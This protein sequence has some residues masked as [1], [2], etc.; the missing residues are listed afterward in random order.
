[1]LVIHGL[2]LVPSLIV[3][4]MEKM[5]V[6]VIGSG[7]AGLGAAWLMARHGVSVTVFESA[8]SAGGHAHTVLPCSETPELAVD[9]G[10]IVFNHATYPN[11]TNLFDELA[12]DVL[13]TNMSFGVSMSDGLEY[14][15]PKF[16][17]LFA[18][19]RNLVR[20]T[21]WRMLF[22]IQKFYEQAETLKPD[23]DKD[24]NYLL[25]NYSKGFSKNHLLPMAAAIWSTDVNDIGEMQGQAF[26]DFFSNH[27]LLK[28]RNRPPWYTVKGGSISYV[29]K[30]LQTPGLQL[31]LNTPIR[32]IERAS[33]HVEVRG[34][35]VKETF[36]QV[37]IATH[38]DQALKLLSKPSPLE[39]KLL[40]EFEYS[41]STAYLH[42]DE[43]LMPSNR[44]AW[45][46]WNYI[47][48]KPG[49]LCV[50]YWMNSLQRL[51]TSKNLFVTLNPSHEPSDSIQVF[52]YSHPTLN[53]RTNIAKKQL[54]ELQ[55]EQRTWFCGSYFGYGFHEDGLQ[56]GL[57]VA[58]EITGKSRPWGEINDRISVVGKRRF[59]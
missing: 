6:A 59:G 37:V 31:K 38:G 36:D 14:A 42:Q 54:W 55:G 43:S 2:L 23:A 58:E 22:D 53:G 12:I 18:Q 33:N 27:G 32:S 51:K 25:R 15:G 41:K 4:Y 5:S 26:I 1:M 45:A 9:V 46:S 40:E 20:P 30:I 52:D 16:N 7:V 48:T 10:F 28:I 11:L 44:R 50:S 39:Q 17:S 19:R 29:N 57:A 34:D 8:S 56:S 49:E 13:P 47:E 21:F 24:L 3:V 35:Q